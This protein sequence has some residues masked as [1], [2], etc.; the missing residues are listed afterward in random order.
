MQPAYGVITPLLGEVLVA[1]FGVGAD[2]I[3]RGLLKQREDS[4]LLG[5]I[6][7]ALK[8]IDEDQLAAAL[9][10]QAE[11]PS[12]RDLPRAEDV[13]ADLIDRLPINFA[14]QH[15]V[16]P[17]TRDAAGRVSVAIADPTRL[18][19]V[20]DVAVL[21]QS[22]VDPVVASASKIID[23]INKTY[24]RLRGGAELEAGHK[25]DEPEDEFGQA[26]ELV[27]MLD[28][29][30]E[31]P[32]IRWVNSLMF[33]AVKDRASDIHVEPGERD[34]MVR[35]RVDGALREAKRAPKKFH[36]SIVARIKIMAGLNIAEK[37]LPQDGRIRRK[38][39]GKDVDM[40]VA[41]VPTATGER[42]TIRLLDRSSVLLGLGDIGMPADMLE[43][44]RGIIKRPHGILL[45]TGPTG[46]GKTTTLYACLSEI[47][48]PDSNILTVEDPVEYQLEGISQTQVNPKI[49]LTF[50]S[51]LRSFLRHDPDVIMVGEIRDRE[52]AEIAIT[53]SLTGHFV[54]ST[55][56]TND[57]AGAIT[58]LVDMGI[59]PFLVASSL[60][61][62]LAQRLARRP[63]KECAV[64]VRPSEQVVRE[65][66]LDP[67]TFYA[68]AYRPPAVIGARVLPP[69]TVLEPRGC[70]ACGDI[71]YRGRT[72][73]YE[74]LM[75][76]DA[77][78]R[79]TLDKADA[80]SIRNAAV[81]AGM[82]T[83]RLDGAR[84][85]L[86]GMTTPEEVMLVTAEAD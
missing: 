25:K 45:V 84:K 58:R 74:L 32:I 11:M 5:E 55:V 18:H 4:G 31:A 63:C 83:L 37:R 15:V 70:P 40:R 61:G 39:A 3:E 6:L 8:L 34:V 17:M 33:Q 16:L 7:V 75:I 44:V 24:A 66:G 38:M 77:V 19:V 14:K 86:Q 72:G 54:F 22:P 47:N 30:D 60:V 82:I 62:L 68:G 21:L 36:A 81:A 85:V 10:I 48:S 26:D 56:H 41:T 43:V 2:A 9:A 73:L 80:G 13:P 69:G 1:Q 20:D 52:T 78:R 64:P 27:D 42:I 53:A 29:N 79:L 28:A 50:A 67:A 76:N 57:A 49:E 23:A 46:S 59:E 35:Y 71:G 12:V 51:G 65:L